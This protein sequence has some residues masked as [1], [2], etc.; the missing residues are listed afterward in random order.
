[1]TVVE[2]DSVS[3]S[4]ALRDCGYSHLNVAAQPISAKHNDSCI[5]LSSA[6]RYIAQHYLSIMFVINQIKDLIA[7]LA[8]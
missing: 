3:P 2:L 5:L 1:M 8:S 4:E 7:F 6:E